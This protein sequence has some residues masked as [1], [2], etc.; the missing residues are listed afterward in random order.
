M[1]QIRTAAVEEVGVNG[2]DRRGN[3]QAENYGELQESQ[4]CIEQ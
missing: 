2:S 4:L 1:Q 3:N